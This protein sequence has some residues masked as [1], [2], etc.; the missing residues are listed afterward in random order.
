MA[1]AGTAP[2]VDVQPLYSFNQSPLIQIYGLPS[3]GQAWT[4]PQGESSLTLRLQIA[5]NY[6]TDTNGSESIHL[7]GESHRFTLA[8]SQGMDWPW[9]P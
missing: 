5:N 8:W 3:L 7:D 1:F 2:A 4:L 6:A 9:R